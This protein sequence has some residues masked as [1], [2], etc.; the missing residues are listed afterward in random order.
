MIKKTVAVALYARCNKMLYT[1]P[2]VEIYRFAAEEGFKVSTE[3][4][5]EDFDPENQI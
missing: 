5:L 2:S 1:K 4:D 3:G